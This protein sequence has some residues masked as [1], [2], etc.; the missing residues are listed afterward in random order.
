MLFRSIRHKLIISI[1]LIVVVLLAL[2]AAGTYTYFRSATEKLIFDQQFTLVT[3]TALDLDQMIE[4]A[5]NALIASAAPLST[6]L[7]RDAGRSQTWLDSQTGIKSIFASGIFLFSPEGKLIAESPFLSDRR[8]KDFSFRDYYRITVDTGKPQISNPYASS[9]GGRPHIM[10]TVP[11]LGA[12]GRLLAILGGAMDLLAADTILHSLTAQKLGS[13]G[14]LYLFTPDR[15][16][17]VH[18]DRSRIMKQ[19][20]HPGANRM[21]DR[22]IEGFEGSGETVNSKGVRFLAS[23]KRLRTTGWILAANYPLE[24]AYQ[25]ITL[26]RNIFIAGIFLVILCAIAISWRIGISISTPLTEFASHIRELSGSGYG[27][28]QRL[29]ENRADELGLLA[30]SFNSLLNDLQ[31]HEEELISSEKRFRQ[32]FEAHSAV[33]LMLEPESGRIV[34][35]NGAAAGFYG[36]SVEQLRAMTISEIN[37]LPPEQLQQDLNSAA[38]GRK[39]IFVSPHQLAD[40]SVR[41]VEIHSTPIRNADT[42]LLYSII[43]DITERITA[44]EEARQSQ[45]RTTQI[46]RLTPSPTF[47]VDLNKTVTSWNHAMFRATGYTAEEAVGQH[48]DFFSEF[49][50]SD[51]CGLFAPE[52]AKPVIARECTLRTKQGEERTISKNVD[53]LR[54]VNGGIIGGIETFEDITERKQSEKKLLDFSSLMEQKNAELGAALIMAEEATQAKSRFLATMSHEIRTPMNGVIGMTGLLLDTELTAEQRGYVEIVHK[55]GENL[56]SLINDILDFSKIE[57]RKLEIENVVFDIRTTLEETA[58]MLALR[59]MQTGLELICRIDPDVPP[60]L[61]GDP[62]RLRQIIT[63]LAGNAIKFT[64]KGEIVISATLESEADGFVVIR[65]EVRDTGIGIPANR[66]DAIFT[67]FTQVDGSTTRKY[68]GTGLGLAISKQLTELLGGQIGIESEEGRG[69]TFWFT[70]TFEKQTGTTQPTEASANA[71]IPGTKILVVDD[72]ATHRM[73]LITLLNHWGCQYETAPDGETA[74]ALLREASETDEPFRLAL[75]DQTMP[76]MDSRTLAR[77]IQADPAI[78]STL[79]ILVTALGARVESAMLKESGFAGCIPKPVRQ[80]QLLKS[81]RDVLDGEKQTPATSQEAITT[82]TDPD[83]DT[84]GIRILLAED[85]IINQKVA[86]NL[87]LRLGYKSDVVAN[88]IEAVR[89]L[90]MI[91][92]DLVLM[93]CQMPDMDGF[94]ATAKIRDPE[95]KVLNHSV[96]IIA[97]TANAMKG[98]REHCITAGMDDYLSKPVKKDEMAA[99]LKKW[100]EQAFGGAEADG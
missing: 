28:R 68:G 56:L 52:V 72:N 27:G 94:E 35:A 59:A 11:V 18:P 16:M 97:M 96:P 61:K 48:C 40:G 81:I 79:L 84:R 90:E 36:Y 3:R 75:I 26:F 93:D 85:N 89:A 77:S 37:P 67:P 70:A 51:Q 31:L 87:L 83:T 54:D 43:Q 24:E 38:T 23:F 7:L 92:Y 58:E 57:A 17:V 86:Q 47:T 44:E 73:L 100:E 14:Y 63:N 66:L 91:R 55:S 32:M 10:M 80:E 62:G 19:D 82:P 98:D 20:V 42:I 41:I 95:S 99:M 15:M 74:L 12:D 6:E 69:S 46:L 49:P 8:G 60:S 5:R 64:P 13:S 78:S 29:D 4:S 50:C 65:F 76:G 34:N 88:G 9:R 45:E 39:N 1:T 33:M 30:K 25:Q 2:T 53:Y 21:Y 71:A 22:A